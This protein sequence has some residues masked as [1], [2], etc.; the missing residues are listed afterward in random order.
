MLLLSGCGGGP[1]VTV[2]E[3]DAASVQSTNAITPLERGVLRREMLGVAEEA[4]AAFLADDPARI[5]ESLPADYVELLAEQRAAYAEEG[6]VRV[7]E[8]S[9][10]SLDIADIN[11]DGTQALAEYNFT[12][13]SYF[14]TLDGAK[15]TEPTGADKVWQLT[16]EGS[17]EDGYVV[18]RMIGAGETF[19]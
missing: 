9:D 16:L 4:V 13:I 2:T 8:H 15:L 1:S 14:E 17:P 11:D 12:D 6:K 3:F 7:R 19:Q 10:V 5:E 18:V